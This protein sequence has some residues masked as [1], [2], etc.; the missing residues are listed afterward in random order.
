[1]DAIILAKVSKMKR[2][3]FLAFKNAVLKRMSTWSKVK[4]S[5]HSALS[6]ILRISDQQH[7]CS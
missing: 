5:I 4:I 6:A 3:A 2:I 1:M 7:V